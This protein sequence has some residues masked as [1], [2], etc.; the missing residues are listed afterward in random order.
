MCL[1]MRRANEAIIRERHVIPKIDDFLTELHGAKYFSKIDLHE[2]YHQIQLYEDSRDITSFAMHEGLFRYKRLIY[3]VSSGFESF[4]KQIEIVIS[5]CPGSKNISDDI[6]I[7]DSSE[8]EHNHHLATVLAR[9]DEAGLK[10]NREKCIPFA[11]STSKITLPSLR[12]CSCSPRKGKG[13]F[14]EVHNRT[15]S[16]P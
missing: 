16:K 5:G 15:H 8:Q 10:V 3:G 13:S 4:E 11:T 2:G 1:D 12:P 9:L 6:L 14:G 7:W